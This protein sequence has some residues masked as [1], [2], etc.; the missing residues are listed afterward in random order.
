MGCPT[1][2]RPLPEPL[3][4]GV[5]HDPTPLLERITA[6]T[7]R[8][9][10]ATST[11][12][13]LD[14]IEDL[15]SH[16]YAEALSGEAQM[17]ALEERLDEIL[18]SGDESRARELRLVVGEHRDVERTVGRLRRALAELH[19]DFVALGGARVAAQR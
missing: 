4:S 18:D 2:A 13:L 10:Q 19:G 1:D 16:G 12:R 7:A 14:E 9:R 15:L 5:M 6:L 11:P 8:A 3:S 17:V